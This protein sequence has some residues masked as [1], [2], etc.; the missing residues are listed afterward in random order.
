M[1]RSKI[2]ILLSLVGLIILSVL[3]VRWFTM[4]IN[5]DFASEALLEFYYDDISISVTITDEDELL[6][7]K[8]I[9]NGRLYFRSDLHCGFTTDV[10]VTM[11]NGKKSITFCPANDGCPLLR[12]GTSRRYLE[13]STESLAKLH[14]IL[15]KYGM[16]FP[17][18]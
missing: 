11:T 3:C 8:Q 7:L 17:C 13:L 4:R 14:E 16:F 15:G 10:S 9:L 5:T 6:L 12:I 2:W 18:V 1:K